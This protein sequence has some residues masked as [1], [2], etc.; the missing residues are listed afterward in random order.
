M[1]SVST[2]AG[3]STLILT[4]LRFT[5]VP[6]QSV[7][8]VSIICPVPPHLGHAVTFWNLPK[9]VL[10]TWDICPL[11]PHWSQ[12]FLLVPGLHPLPPQVLHLTFFEISICLLHPKSASVKS[13]VTVF[14]RSLPFCGP[15]LRLLVLPPPMPPNISNMSSKFM[16]APPKPPPKFPKPPKPPKPP[17]PAPKFG[18]TPANPNLSYL[19]FL[20]GSERIS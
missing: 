13:I 17:W 9:G 14:C 20:S 1:L 2:P 8:G 18:S 5:P 12:V 10:L 19:S 4:V 6:P 3:M 15:P 16:P 7:H 11:P